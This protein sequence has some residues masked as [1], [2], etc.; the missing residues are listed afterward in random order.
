M[1]IE[2]KDWTKQID[3]LHVLGL[4]QLHEVYSEMLATAHDIGYVVPDECLVETDDDT[5]LRS[6]IEK[7]HPEIVTFAEE[8]TRAPKEPKVPAEKP[9]RG[10]KKAAGEKP[11]TKAPKKPAKAAVQ[12]EPEQEDTTMNAKKKTTKTPAKKAAKAPAKKVAKAAAKKGSAANARTPVGRSKFKDDQV[13][14]VKLKDNPAKAG[15]GRYDRVANLIK[16]NGK[17]VGQFFKSGGK[18]G[19]LNYS[20]EQG[21]ITIK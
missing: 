14:N 6:V 15:T 3:D 16:H 10:G 9:A 19:T 4:E 2:I 11:A 18:S 8:N 21:W 12:K 13:I 7:I 5:V 20:V 17:T 1:P